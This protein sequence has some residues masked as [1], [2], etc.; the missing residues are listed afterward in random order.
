MSTRFN[1]AS[2][3]CAASCTWA[4][5]LGIEGMYVALRLPRHV[6]RRVTRRIDEIQL[7]VAQPGDPLRRQADPQAKRHGLAGVRHLADLLG[8]DR[9]AHEHQAIGVALELDRLPAAVFGAGQT[10]IGHPADRYA[11]I[12]DGRA[13]LQS[14]HRL[15][16]VGLEQRAMD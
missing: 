7:Q 2:T 14:L 4:N 8:I 6:L 11:A 1:F 13:D 12:L 5:V 16:E 10:D 9:I 15:A 3:C